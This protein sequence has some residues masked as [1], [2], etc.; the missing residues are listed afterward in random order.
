[1]FSINSIWGCGLTRFDGYSK[2]RYGFLLILRLSALELQGKQQP[3]WPEKNR[4][5]PIKV[6][7]KWFH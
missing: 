1:M 3:V 2:G 6:A 7:Q 5:I 4:Q